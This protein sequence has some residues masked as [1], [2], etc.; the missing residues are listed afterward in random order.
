MVSG[1][2]KP[3]DEKLSRSVFVQFC[4]SIIEM[5]HCLPTREDWFLQW[6]PERREVEVDIDFAP[7][8]SL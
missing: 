7:V 4:I 6:V 1:N 8:A 5:S 2:K 3:L